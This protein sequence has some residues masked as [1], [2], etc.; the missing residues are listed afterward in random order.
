MYHKKLSRNRSRY[1]H[2]GPAQVKICS[3]RAS[4]ASLAAF[5][6]W[7]C[8]T[9]EQN[10][11]LGRGGSSEEGLWYWHS[12]RYLTLIG[13]VW[14]RRLPIWSWII[15]LK[16]YFAF[17]KPQS[18]LSWNAISG[19]FKS[20]GSIE[21]NG[22]FWWK[23]VWFRMCKQYVIYLRLWL[24]LHLRQR[25][26][27]KSSQNHNHRYLRRAV[28]QPPAQ[29][30]MSS[31]E[32]LLGYLGLDPVGCYKPLVLETPQP[33]WAAFS[34]VQFLLVSSLSPQNFSFGPVTISLASM[35]VVSQSPSTHYCEESGS[36]F[37]ITSFSL[38]EGCY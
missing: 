36:V 8:T 37:L 16:M 25:V 18:Y 14:W 38:F 5:L 28:V 20:L 13:I 21:S 23:Q 26:L 7:S 12:I 10:P 6:L 2:K 34:T 15:S 19:A 17:Q 33:F 30:R 27:P 4:L 31:Y 35:S 32:V 29:S 1:I 22:N 11:L 3:D 9:V 24:T